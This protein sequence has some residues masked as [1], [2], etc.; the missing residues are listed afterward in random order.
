M[1]FPLAFLV[2]LLIARLARRW[3]PSLLGA[4][5]IPEQVNN[6]FSCC[7]IRN[8]FPHGDHVLA[9]SSHNLRP[10]L[11]GMLLRIRQGVALSTG[12]GKEYRAFRP[13]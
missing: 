1:F 4:S 3:E 7:R 6:R 9:H 2:N 5:S 12:G 11:R 13:G 10:L 8:V